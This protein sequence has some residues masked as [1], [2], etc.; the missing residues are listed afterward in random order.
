MKSNH[1]TV[2][3][4]AVGA[5]A[6]HA[7]PEAFSQ[8]TIP[9]RPVGTITANPTV[10]Q[11][12]TKPAL[13]WQIQYPTN[14][15]N[16]LVVNPPGTL[17]LSQDLYASVQ[18]VGTGVTPCVASPGSPNIY[19]DA[20]ISLN[21]GAYM[22]LFYGTRTDM[23]CTK[24]L[25]VKLVHANQ[26]IDFGGRYVINGAW[27]PFYTTRSANFQIVALANGDIPPTTRALYQSSTL[28]SYLKPY[29]DASGKVKIG[30]MSVLIL[31]ELNQTNHNM[32]CFDL[33]DQVLLVS[34]ST[35]HPNNGHGNNL[36]GVD[37]S[38]PGQGHGGPNGLAD[39]SGG[40]DDEI[41]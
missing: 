8:T 37:C 34:F 15:G 27:G 13:N 9:T 12:G 33:Q 6:I 1:I 21:G 19:T 31:M 32:T 26:T 2:T 28:A 23:D 11:T 38:N 40:V 17:I 20:R 18:I 41:R 25:F 36:D 5:I 10:V 30:P 14:V 24:P 16:V 4:V 22:Q 39:P 3:L 35:K 29:L 7:S